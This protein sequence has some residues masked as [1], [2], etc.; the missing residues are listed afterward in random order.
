MSVKTQYAHRV[1]RF[2][3]ALDLVEDKSRLVVTGR[4]WGPSEYNEE[5]HSVKVQLEIRKCG[6]LE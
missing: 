2:L 3:R 5:L 6:S 1:H 4:E